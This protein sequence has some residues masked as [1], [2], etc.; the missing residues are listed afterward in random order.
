[1]QLYPELDD[2]DFHK[3]IFE[4][5]EYQST[6]YPVDYYKTISL[7]DKCNAQS[8]NVE[9][10]Q[11]FLSRFMSPDT[12]YKSLL[13]FHGVGTGKTCAALTI[14]EG[15]KKTLTNLR[16]RLQVKR[17]TRNFMYYNYP[18]VYVISSRAIHK[19]F[20]NELY[21]TNKVP[22]EEAPGMLHCLGNEYFP[23]N[24]DSEGA[25]QKLQV[26]RKILSYYSFFGPSEFS[27]FVRD[28][29]KV[30]NLQDF[31][32]HS[33]FIVDEV[34]NVLSEEKE[35]GDA[36]NNTLET[37]K[38]V[39]KEA[40]DTRLIMLSATPMRDDEESIINLL[41]LLRY[42]DNKYE[43]IQKDKLFSKGNVN[44][45]YLAELAR[46]Y[47]SYLRGNNPV[48]FPAMVMP[49]MIYKPNP[50]LKIN[51]EP[52]IVDDRMYELFKCEMSEFQYSFYA[53][54]KED[55]GLQHIKLREAATIVYPSGDIGDTGF[56]KSFKIN[57]G[58][59]SFINENF[60]LEQNVEK[61]SKKIYELLKIART[62]KGLHYI[63]S[64][65]DK[66]G[67]LTIA[68]AFEANGYAFYSK[69]GKHDQNGRFVGG[70]KLL[71][72]M[73]NARC[74][75]CGNLQQEDHIE[76]KFKQGTFILFTGSET[77]GVQDAL[78]VYN[79]VENK[80]GHLIKFVIGSLVSAEGVDYKRIKH[81]H[82]INPWYNFTRTWQAIGR[83]LRNCSQADFPE[84]ER[85]VVVYLYS[86]TSSDNV[87]ETIDE[88]MYR[89][90]LEKD[91]RIKEVERT[92]KSVSI[93]CFL[94]KEANKYASDKDYSRD[95]DYKE[96]S[97]QCS[98]EPD[99][100][101]KAP[102]KETFNIR[103]ND[104][105]IRKASNLIFLLFKKKGF[106]KLEEIASSLKSF[107]DEEY[108]FI[109]L[110]RYIT[111][112][113]VLKD[114]Y[115]RPGF[116]VYKNGY[117]FYQPNEFDDVEAPVR[118]KQTPLKLKTNNVTVVAPPKVSK[119]LSIEKEKKDELVIIDDNAL[120]NI[121]LQPTLELMMYYFD[122][123]NEKTIINITDSL[124]KKGY[125][126]EV[127]ILQ[128]LEHL[129][130]IGF[131]LA[132]P[133]DAAKHNEELYWNNKIVAYIGRKAGYWSDNNNIVVLT[134]SG[135]MMSLTSMA[136][137][138]ELLDYN[139][140]PS[141]KL[142]SQYEE[143]CYLH[144][145]ISYKEQR[146]FK[147]LYNPTQES[148]KAADKRKKPTGKS[149]LSYQVGQLKDFMQ[150]LDSSINADVMT[151]NTLV[152]EI[153]LELRRKSQN[154]DRNFTWF[155]RNKK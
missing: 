23:V 151:K 33:I 117:Y 152:K 12:P 98:F 132:E 16:K 22:R 39:F 19:V 45:S 108:I 70:K 40:S 144:G 1:M 38:E 9:N 122:S 109:A 21:N 106:Y 2:P 55:Y 121:L 123:Y 105:E 73:K 46:G 130:K 134:K 44:H 67:A 58:V 5:E 60:L 65:F 75:I 30:T 80:D 41:T 78:Q 127:K 113:H 94:N 49:L 148:M 150:C 146:E 118:Y 96:C 147:I 91:I 42:N 66:S 79:S 100:E 10:H 71:S 153:E 92:L 154:N 135:N 50:S 110:T 119:T 6:Q 124:L 140:L 63:Y 86:S 53:K 35:L 57:K 90:S 24:D 77:A 115:S 17:G 83:G 89:L 36:K 4:K 52:Y 129:R 112:K 137:I 72:N 84:G 142:S 69:E 93:D 56:D 62:Q 28:I 59:Y 120:R 25:N 7:E 14:A 138:S 29:K 8:F 131:V 34:H 18:G 114:K 27:N 104:P 61:Y 107:V 47:V 87:M 31:F 15:Y 54:L 51:G 88:Q 155:V 76:H 99:D 101:N 143:G 145:I 68:L 139:E 85:N 95:C 82:V 26:S 97:F 149:A 43:E 126:E 64:L 116:M 141:K 37:L 3:K 74:A 103:S 11:V 102:N 128:L 136:K 32:S 20:R 125:N 133:Y 111:K 48:S 81:L 13:L